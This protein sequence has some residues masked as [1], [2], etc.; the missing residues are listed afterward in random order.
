VEQT[1]RFSAS[2]ADAR[3]R[4][5]QFVHITDVIDHTLSAAMEGIEGNSISLEKIVDSNLPMVRAD[6]NLLSECL[7]NL[8]SNA[9]KY[10]GEAQ[11]L[12]IRAPTVETGMARVWKSQWKTTA[13]HFLR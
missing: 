5:I 11:W 2:K 3:P 6:H 9:L 7:L 8:I 12:D 10:G 4:D 1:L 13:W